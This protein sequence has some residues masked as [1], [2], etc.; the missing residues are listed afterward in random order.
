MRDSSS[1]EPQ[2]SEVQPAELQP[3]ESQPAEIQPAEAQPRLSAVPLVPDDT[4]RPSIVAAAEQ[5]A[6][7]PIA[8]LLMKFEPLGCDCELGFVQRVCGVEPLGLMRFS[9]MRL[10]H[11]IRGIQTNFAG[12]AEDIDARVSL[13]GDWDLDQPAYQLMSHTGRK[14]SEIDKQTLLEQQRR[15]IAYLRDALVDDLAEGE[16]I[17]VVWWTDPLTEADVTPLWDAIRAHGPGRLLW[18]VKGEP[19]GVVQEIKPGLMRGT[20]DRWRDVLLDPSDRI[21]LQGWLTVLVNTWLLCRESPSEQ[22]PQQQDLGQ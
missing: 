11:M 8:D 14:A 17:F 10:H 21:T 15:R 16:K 20:I 13:D 5:V 1:P 3:A 4:S 7:I 2:T 22:V 6:G 19:A 9:Y 12:L 18:M